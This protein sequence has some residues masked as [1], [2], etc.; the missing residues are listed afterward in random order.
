MRKKTGLIIG[1][2]RWKKDLCEG[3]VIEVQKCG[4]I[5]KGKRFKIKYQ[6]EWGAFIADGVDNILLFLLAQNSKWTNGEKLDIS[7]CKLV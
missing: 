7:K 3:D 2:G 1:K 4:L 6:K 5:L